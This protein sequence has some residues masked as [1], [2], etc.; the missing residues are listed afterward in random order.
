[1][2]SI[3]DVQVVWAVCVLALGLVRGGTLGRLVT[4]LG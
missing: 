1:M 2:I 3:D 4:W